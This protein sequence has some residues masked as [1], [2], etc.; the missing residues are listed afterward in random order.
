MNRS[1]LLVFQVLSSKDKEILIAQGTVRCDESPFGSDTH[2]T[3]AHDDLSIT[4]KTTHGEFGFE[5]E[6]N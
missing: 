4:A 2:V 5:K 3:D 1:F 6:D